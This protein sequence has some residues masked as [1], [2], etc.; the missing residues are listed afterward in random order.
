MTDYLEIFNMN[1]FLALI[2]R[3]DFIDL[4][5]FGHLHI[6]GDMKAE[7]DVPVEELSKHNEVF[8]A[9]SQNAN[10]FDN[11]FSY[12]IIHY[13]KSINDLNSN[14]VYIEEVKN[15]YPLDYQSKRQFED[16]F[17]QRIRIEEPIWNDSVF[18][19]QKHQEF[20]AC[21]KGAQNMMKIIGFEN[22]DFRCEEFI[23]DEIVKELV[24]QLFND[25][26][27]EGEMPI[28]VYLLRYER[29]SSYP[30][31]TLG[32]FMDMVNVVCNRHAKREVDAIAIKKTGIYQLLD[33][34]R[35]RDDARFE[36][37]YQSIQQNAQKFIEMT[38]S[39]EHGIDFIKTATLFLILRDKYTDDFY[40]EEEFISYCKNF[41][42]D[43]KL[44]AYMLGIVLGHNHTYD[45]LYEKL[46][47]AIFKNDKPQDAPIKEDGD[48][49]SDQDGHTEPPFQEGSSES[50]KASEETAQEGNEK[51][52]EITEQIELSASEEEKEDKTKNG[53]QTEVE[54]ESKMNNLD[55]IGSNNNSKSDN[56]S[57]VSNVETSEDVSLKPANQETTNSTLR[58]LP[59][60]PC[61][62]GVPKKGKGGGIK[63]TPKPVEVFTREKYI[64]YL[65]K[66]YVVIPE[67]KE[68]S[69]F[70]NN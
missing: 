61:R 63:K 50:G 52:P 11:A 62:M 20:L 60:L 27:P 58:V 34:F 1:H 68:K 51:V 57:C 56:N 37:I 6:N 15:I 47:L 16:T 53:D 9:L 38:K 7:F 36:T 4:F 29:H 44:A 5:N 8:T 31:N 35:V 66:G 45:C 21:K 3:A 22:T 67:E 39:Y 64:E 40:Y 32:C 17:D 19:L 12:L 59:K 14:D 10:S 41:G 30:K 49:K 69:I 26:R 54:I 23:T 48:D 24:N 18:E 42:E 55:S 2:R 43:F 65:D 33:E 46:P 28:W 25:S 70:D 13:T